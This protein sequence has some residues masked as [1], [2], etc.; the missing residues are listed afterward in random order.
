MI[1][2]ARGPT[3]VRRFIRRRQ[4]LSFAAMR[5]VLGYALAVLA[6]GY[7]PVA[8]P[9]LGRAPALRFFVLPLGVGSLLAAWQ[10]DGRPV[11][12]VFRSL[13]AWCLR[14]GRLVAWRAARPAERVLLSAVT[15]VPD[16]R[17]ARLRRAVISGP[18]HLLVRYPVTWR[19]HWHTMFLEPQPGPPLQCHRRIAVED[20][21]RVV[22]R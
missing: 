13:L 20:G 15:I 2:S 8:A 11:H 19:Y 21:H 14:P 16:D 5:R 22:I 17:G 9:L 18:V 1:T 4:G 6:L 3:T 10:I 12:S 7:L